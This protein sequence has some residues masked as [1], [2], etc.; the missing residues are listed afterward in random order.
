MLACASGPVLA[1]PRSAALPFLPDIRATSPLPGTPPTP[2]T[3]NSIVGADRFYDAGYAGFGVVI[4]NAE[5]GH[6]WGGT[7]PNAA[8]GSIEAGHSFLRGQVS[9]YVGTPSFSPG[10]PV[11]YDFHATMVGH[12]LAGAGPLTG[13]S[14]G[15]APFSQ[16]WSGAIATKFGDPGSP[17]PSG[18]FAITDTSFHQVYA[19]FST[20]PTG[21]AAVRM[22]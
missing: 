3:I 6:I 7:D 11:E 1:G 15:I 22:L 13:S 12:A 9:R 18:S 21:L 4:G 17:R 19:D 20:G 5:A 8:A 10:F 2:Y 16:L 14:M